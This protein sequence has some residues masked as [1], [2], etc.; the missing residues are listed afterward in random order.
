MLNIYNFFKNLSTKSNN[1]LNNKSKVNNFIIISLLFIIIFLQQGFS[2]SQGSIYSNS[3]ELEII[4]N[5]GVELM[6]NSP[7]PILNELRINSHYVLLNITDYQII[8]NEKIIPSTIKNE[9]VMKNNEKENLFR[10][11]L[12]VDKDVPESRNIEIQNTY[13]VNSNPFFP[14][15]TS[16]KDYPLDTFKLEKYSNYLQFTE[17]INTNEE[18]QQKA[19]E[20]A[21]KEDDVFVIAT[22]IANWLEKEIEYDLS[23]I[24]ENPNQNAVEIFNSKRGVCKELSIIYISM[25]RS[26]QIPARLALGYSYTNSQD[27]IDLV[28]DNWGGHA[29]VEVLIGDEWVP[30]DLAYKQYGYVGSTHILFQRSADIDE[31][32]V[33]VEMSSRGYQF[34]PNSLT[35]SMNFNVLNQV[36]SNLIQETSLNSILNSSHKEYQSGSYVLIEAIIENPHNYYIAQEFQLVF[37]QELI[38]ITP[39]SQLLSLR[40]NSKTKVGYL[41]QIS[42][43]MDNF[44]FPISLYSIS[45]LRSQELSSFDIVSTQRGV[46]HTRDYV[47]LRLEILEN[48]NSILLSLYDENKVEQE[49]EEDIENLILNIKNNENLE[50]DSVYEELN[51][52]ENVKIIDSSIDS[53]IDNLIQEKLLNYNTKD[54]CKYQLD[55]D[56][57]IIVKQFD[58]KND[59]KNTQLYLECN[60]VNFFEEL[61]EQIFDD[62]KNLNIEQEQL[63]KYVFDISLCSSNCSNLNVTLDK[64]LLEGMSNKVIMRTPTRL[65]TSSVLRINSNP[66]PITLDF[67]EHSN[68]DIEIQMK[69]NGNLE[70][71]NKNFQNLN[72]NTN[73][74]LKELIVIEIIDIELENIVQTIFLNNLDDKVEI[75]LKEGS[76]EFNINLFLYNDLIQEERKIIRITQETI[77]DSILSFFKDF[78]MYITSVF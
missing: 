59:L 67:V 40:P 77:K 76:Y 42:Q 2:Q 48:E 8:R 32:G 60:L 11:Y 45:N 35:S 66:K 47:D 38:E 63:K 61:I 18:L 1:K 65:H 12:V 9:V 58:S 20:L 17:M 49:R 26:L 16:K 6:E 56:L 43:E 71:I 27:I 30:F 3:L 5:L 31:L 62:I 74:N 33:Y 57:E 55:S 44:I 75:N 51:E 53:F 46:F 54:S 69:D 29:W 15:V 14:K 22:K 37:P 21:N 23:T 50:V 68:L 36:D 19:F 72:S 41:L 39:S 10:E 13:V 52:K 34:A 64:L 73:R 25:L 78:W 24:F 4:H 70:L 28:G 7:N